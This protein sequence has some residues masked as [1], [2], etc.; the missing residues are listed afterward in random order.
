MIHPNTPTADEAIRLSILVPVYGVETWIET[1]ARS[2]FE[3]TLQKRIEFIFVDDAS[4]DGSIDRLERVL[5]Q[6]P[7]R[8]AQTRIV[9]HP[10][11]RG[12]A[13]ARRSAIEAAR[14]TW[15]LYVDSDDLLRADAAARLLAAADA[16]PQA[17]MIFGGYYATKDPLSD[18]PSCWQRFFPPRDQRDQVVRDMLTQS[19][20]VANSLVGILIRRT[21]W[22]DH[23]IHLTEG[24]NFAE[25]YSV[26]PRLVHAAR[27]IATVDE[28]FYGYRIAR[29]GSYMQ[30]ID[31]RAASQYVAACRVVSD[32]M[33][34]QPDYARWRESILLGRLNIKKWIL[35]RGLNPEAYDAQLFYDGDRPHRLMQRLY[36]AAIKSGK[37]FPARLMG[38]VTN[39]LHR[40][41]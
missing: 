13:I 16:H 8:I 1:C 23:N 40:W 15:L 9:R 41:S 31:D 25:D 37:P 34:Q 17:D 30:R 11:N 19:H 22:T 14:G 5:A 29:D 33:K 10:Q 35:K 7:A 2:L 27:A 39:L 3:Q 21:L 28:L 32:Y 4:P 12:V 36:A 38:L 18:A 26:M 20:R 24:I 6:Y